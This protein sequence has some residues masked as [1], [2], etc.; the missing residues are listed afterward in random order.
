[1]ND[2]TPRQKEKMINRNLIKT[3]LSHAIFLPCFMVTHAYADIVGTPSINVTFTSTI[4]AGTCATV[5]KD[6]SG[7]TASVIDFKD[8][9]RSDLDKKNRKEDFKIVFSSCAGVKSANITTAQSSCSGGASDGDSFANSGGTAAATAV[10]IWKE[11]PDS[12]VQFS[13]KNKG[14]GQNIA[15]T[16]ASDTEVNLTARMVIAKGRSASE[17]T[18]GSFSAPVTFLI[19]Y[20]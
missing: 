11:Q 2:S 16:S 8:V 14:S 4:E 3:V 6:A 18:A 7:A 5:L 13:C 1:M 17:V 19:T 20:Q 12:G 9:F 10:E 15:L